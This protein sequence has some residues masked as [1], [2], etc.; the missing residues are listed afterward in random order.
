MRLSLLALAILALAAP[1]AG[2]TASGAGDFG[3]DSS[4]W[5]ND[6]ACDDTRFVGDR[7]AGAWTSSDDHV[8]RDA[9]DCR[10]LLNAGRIQWGPVSG[11]GTNPDRFRLFTR[12][13]P[14]GIIVSVQGDQA[15]E[16]ELTEERVRTMAESRLRAA[17]L[18]GSRE[19]V[20]YLAV[21]IFTLDDGPAFVT[22]I[23]LAKSLR[24]D[25]TGLERG[26]DTWESLGY[27]THSG[28]AGFIMQGLSEDLDG[29]I[30]EYLRVNEG[31]C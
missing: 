21:F 12:C 11:E 16:I 14:L 18:Y 5:A 22:Q 23:S 26:S 27:G 24:D 7:G 20:P 6:G 4:E 29:F 25:M 8:G 9:T 28:D 15:D 30:L 1:L 31:Y 2:Q 10:N 17:R 19:G 13:A 3:D